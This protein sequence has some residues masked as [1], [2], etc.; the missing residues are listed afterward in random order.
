MAYGVSVFDASTGK[1]RWVGT[2]DKN[3]A[4]VANAEAEAGSVLT[5]ETFSEF[6]DV[7]LA[8]RKPFIEPTT[9]D[10]YRFYLRRARAFFGDKPLHAITDRDCAALS[11]SIATEMAPLTACAMLIAVQAVLQDGAP[12]LGKLTKPK[13]PQRQH[14]IRPLTRSEHAHLLFTCPGQYRTMFAVWPYLGLRPSEMWGLR[15]CDIQAD[16][17]HIDRQRVR[18]ITRPPKYGSKR[19]VPLTPSMRA[20][21]EAHRPTWSEGGWLFTTAQGS[22]LSAAN[23][24]GIIWQKIRADADLPD[25]HLHDLRHTFASWC[26][27]GGLDVRTLSEYLGHRSAKITLDTYCHLIPSADDEKAAALARALASS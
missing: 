25:V 4:S 7:W 27:A 6:A 23:F 12:K 19:V 22:N 2:F 10:N 5:D 24:G 16:G 15:A 17:L 14:D 20:L 21:L 11:A 1:Q 26:L 13:R 8:N 18:G 3:G 9:Y